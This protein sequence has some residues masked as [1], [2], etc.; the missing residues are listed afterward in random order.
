MSTR[1]FVVVFSS[2]VLALGG[3]KV[4]DLAY[5][6]GRVHSLSLNRYLVLM[7]YTSLCDI[8]VYF[9]NCIFRHCMTY[10]NPNP[11]SYWRYLGGGFVVV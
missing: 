5:I 1:K 6:L 9:R 2:V 11:I 3:T 10:L 8:L 4:R 7:A